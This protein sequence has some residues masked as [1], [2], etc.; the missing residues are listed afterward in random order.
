MMEHRSSKTWTLPELL[1]GLNEV[2]EGYEKLDDYLPAKSASEFNIAP[3]STPRSR[4]PTP[5]PHYDPRTCCFCYSPNHRSTRCYHYMPVASRRVIA[6][7]L[8]LCWKC[9]RYG[10]TSSSCDRPQCPSCNGNHHHLLCS[11]SCRRGGR[12]P[13]PGRHHYP[14]RP[15]STSR[16]SSRSYGRSPSYDK[17]YSRSPSRSSSYSPRRSYDTSPS[18]RHRGS[19]RR[20]RTQHHT[21]RFRS[22]VRDTIPSRENSTE[23]ERHQ[24]RDSPVY[25]AANSDEEYEDLI[26]HL[27]NPSDTQVC[28][29]LDHSTLSS[30]M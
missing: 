7:T 19:Y 11:R 15:R 5:E 4:S 20:E 3:V 9:L 10:H 17:S 26:R 16:S 8:R 13:S 23:R 28:T 6:N 22:P 25:V 24:G 1:D 30:L 21:I 27:K 2:I 14:H 18:P 29:T 12:S